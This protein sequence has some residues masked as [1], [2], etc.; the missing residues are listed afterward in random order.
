MDFRGVHEEQILNSLSN[1]DKIHCG[2]FD[3][4]RITYTAQPKWQRW[5]SAGL[6]ALGLTT[7]NCRVFAQQKGGA[8]G[9][10]T[11]LV[12][13]GVAADSINNQ[14]T[15]GIFSFSAQPEYI[16]GMARFYDYIK[17]NLSKVSVKEVQTTIV[18]FSIEKDG[19]LVNTKLVSKENNKIDEQLIRLIKGSRKWKPGIIN[20]RPVVIDY[21][22]TVT[23]TATGS[24]DI[25][26][27]QIN[28][29]ASK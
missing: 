12:K 18:K 20:S 5:L 25:D 7:V 26:V 19:T 4:G 17:K 28:Q 10:D 16:G 13:P 6:I 9:S 15:L 23:V 14:I 11:T 24:I 21:K 29:T 2:I 27:E 3:A 22:C 1:A 8:S